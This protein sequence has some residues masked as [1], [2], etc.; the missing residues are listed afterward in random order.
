MFASY[1][2]LAAAIF[3]MPKE[4]AAQIVYSDPADIV[5]NG[6]GAAADIDLN[7]DGLDDM[8]FK[9]EHGVYPGPL[10]LIKP[11]PGA[12]LSVEAVNYP[13]FTGGFSSST[14]VL[15]FPTGK[16]VKDGNK[17][18]NLQWQ[19]VFLLRDDGYYATNCQQW[20]GA[21]NMFMGFR[22]N[23]D[24]QFYN[25]GW[26]RM[27]VHQNG[28]QMVIKDWAINMEK[29]KPILTGQTMR[30]GDEE[31]E[32]QPALNVYSYGKE[33]YVNGNTGNL[34]LEIT[35]YNAYGEKLTALNTNDV[36]A[37]IAVSNWSSGSYLVQVKTAGNSF[38]R[39]VIIQ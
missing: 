12:Y 7:N 15:A 29:N 22:I 13:C 21:S 25:Y 11:Q 17:W 35:V 9:I 33:I 31:G 23:H 34:P 10:I 3:L 19:Y 4:A 2:G 24:F 8:R 18:T 37:T 39:K 16:K 30:M 27:S 20:K 26:M 32:L 28:T 5:L 14:A 38:S 36:S 6:Y 1:S